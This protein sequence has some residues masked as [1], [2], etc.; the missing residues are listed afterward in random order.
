MTA[1]FVVDSSVA[2]AWC[3]ADE[4]TPATA[5]L[6][7][8]MEN[9]AA[10]VPGWWFLEIINVLAISE[11]KRRITA[12]K[13]VEFLTLIDRFQWE[14]DTEAP[15]GPSHTS[16]RSAARINS[17][18]TTPSISNSHFAG[19]YRWQPSMSHC[20]KR[21]KKRALSCSETRHPVNAYR[22]SRMAALWRR[23]PNSYE[24]LR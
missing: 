15:R 23:H 5:R 13:T 16:C 22:R 18:V 20:G 17:P 7:N 1:S 12:E 6:Y 11:R 9:E 21:Q 3:F 10:A 24:I 4:A 2:L 8:R 14:I 19:D